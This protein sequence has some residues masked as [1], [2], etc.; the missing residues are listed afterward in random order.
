[1]PQSF[2]PP[3]IPWA[4]PPAQVLER[5]QR[6][7]WEAQLAREEAVTRV[8]D[9]R[10]LRSERRRWGAVW[11]ECLADPDYLMVC[12]AYCARVRIHDGTWGGIPTGVRRLVER[13]PA[14]PVSHGICPDCMS[15]HFPS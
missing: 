8:A 15:R 9:C 11:S 5:A 6:L 3:S 13:R 4:E 7:C 12:C 10:R 1:M 14:L 2:I